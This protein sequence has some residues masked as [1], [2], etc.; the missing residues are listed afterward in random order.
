M[1][2]ITNQVT[3]FAAL[4]RLLDVKMRDITPPRRRVD[5]NAW[6]DKRP[7]A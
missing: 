3:G 1:Y 4:D 6:I 7:E 5:G 2:K